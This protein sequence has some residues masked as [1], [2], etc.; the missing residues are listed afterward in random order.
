MIAAA[1]P[2]IRS[3]DSD[4][5]VLVGGLAAYGRRHGVSPLRFVRELACVDR[6]LR[7][8]RRAECAGFDRVEGDG[9][10]FHPYST[11]T[12]PESVEPGASPDDVP[13]ARIGALARLLHRLVAAGRLAPGLGD[14]YITEFGYESDPPDPGAPFDPGGAARA[15]LRAE[16]I[17]AR[18]PR[19][20]TFAQFL[21]RDLPATPGGQHQGSVPDWQSGLLFRD[22]R[23]KPLAKQ[24]RR[25]RLGVGFRR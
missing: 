8:L 12:R 17:A 2:A 5:K 7:P 9:F 6:F 15:W 4:A 14:I 19:V 18:E 13:I 24:L 25:R 11:Q 3:V 1:V 21:I 10:A 16:A 22:G 23:E 20:R